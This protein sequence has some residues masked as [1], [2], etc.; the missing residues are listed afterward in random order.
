[1]MRNKN[2]LMMIFVTS[3]LLLSGCEDKL[4]SLF[5]SKSPEQ[6]LGEVTAKYSSGNYGD[7]KTQGES[8][9]KKVGPNQ[10]DF[11]LIVAKACAKLGDADSALNYLELAIKL[12][13]INPQQAMFEPAFET[14]RTE[15]R[16]V[17]L[18]AGHGGHQQTSQTQSVQAPVKREPSTAV[19][20]DGNGIEASAGGVS[21]KIAP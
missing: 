10:G 20:I 5:G 14:I 3:M 8:F 7:V 15:M 13:S 18:V 11:A 2:I 9:A 16:F 17:S 12:Q 19:K 21:V 1:M 4:G 6:I